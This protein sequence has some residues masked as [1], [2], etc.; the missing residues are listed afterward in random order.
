MLP[1]E[2]RR[3]LA[4]GGDSEGGLLEVVRL[5]V[6]VRLLVQGGIRKLCRGRWRGDSIGSGSGG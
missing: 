5:F 2:E 3:T 1:W 4:E 6:V